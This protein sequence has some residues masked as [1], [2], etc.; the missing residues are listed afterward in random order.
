[1]RLRTLLLRSAA[2][3]KYVLLGGIVVLSLFQF[4]LIAQAAEI[5]RS[6]A[7]GRMAEFVPAFLQRGLGQQALLL[8]TFKGTVSF[9]Y[10]HPVI[11][12]LL[13]LIAIYIA[14][15]PAHEVESGLV[16]LVLARSVPR[17]RL[18]TRSLLLAMGSVAAITGFMLCGTFIGL[19]WLAPEIESVTFRLI[20]RLAVNLVAVAWCCGAIGVFLAALSRRWTTAFTTGA[21]IVIVG[22]LIDFLALGW[23]PARA[24]SWFFPFQYF[25]ALLILGGTAAPWRDLV[26]LSSA[27]AGFAVLA[28]WRF[29]KRDL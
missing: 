1:M 14:T 22:Y 9:G 13:S 19:R 2:Q 27:T 11:V 7:F 24:L 25:P 28:Y 20:G 23:P 17:H 16:D 15:E 10:F 21:L 5:E 6:N 26:V 8:A 3:S 12:C 29:E 18:I 4:L